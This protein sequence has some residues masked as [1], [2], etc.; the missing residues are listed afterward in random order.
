MLVKTLA[1]GECN[2][3]AII[4]VLYLAGVYTALIMAGELTLGNPYFLVTLWQFTAIAPWQ[5]SL[6]I[7]A[8][9]FLWL[10]LWDKLLKPLWLKVFIISLFFITGEFTNLLWLHYFDYTDLALVGRPGAF[11]L[12]IILYLI[13]VSI[14]I[15]FYRF[16]QQ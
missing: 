13:L 8:A 5:W 11:I 12:V 9:G 2:S 1:Y 4:K 16:I 15:S 6:P 10:L 14:S 3:E 7:H